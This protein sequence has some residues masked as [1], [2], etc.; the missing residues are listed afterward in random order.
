MSIVIKG[1]H[2]RFFDDVIIRYFDYMVDIYIYLIKLYRIKG[3]NT[4]VQVK[5]G[6]YEKR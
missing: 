6:R 2:K 3:R 1:Q 4:R 5:L